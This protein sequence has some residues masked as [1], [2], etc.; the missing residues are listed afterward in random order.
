M[1]TS[2]V[3]H[4]HRR[5]RKGTLNWEYAYT[6]NGK[7][8]IIYSKSLFEL[9]RRVK[10]MNL[11]WTVKDEDIYEDNITR[12]LEEMDDVCILDVYR[13]QNT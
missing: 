7:N 8:K 11:S 1:T 6:I 5:M 9:E 13:R 10:S 4:V 2:G 3:L 12:E